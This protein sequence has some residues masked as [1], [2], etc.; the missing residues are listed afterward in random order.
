MAKQ[1]S[2]DQQAEGGPSVF[3]LNK[4]FGAIV[5]RQHKFWAEGTEFEAGKDDAV[6][7]LLARSGADLTQK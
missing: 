5:A 4:S 6:I 3:V 7:S 2:T 1:K